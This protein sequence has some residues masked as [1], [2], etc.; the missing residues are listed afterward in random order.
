MA[1]LSSQ[2]GFVENQIYS[3]LILENLHEG[4]LPDIYFRNVTDFASGGTL[5][6]PTVGAVTLQDI[7]EDEDPTYNPIDSGTVN[8]TITEQVGDAWYITDDMRED[9][10]LVDSL[11]AARADEGSRALKEYFQ[12]TAFQALY[13]AQTASD[14]NN[15]NGFSHRF[16]AS[17]G[18]EQMLIGDFNDMGLAFDKAN[19]P[20]QGRV[21]IVD[22]V[23]A[24]TLEKAYNVNYNV[25]SNP[26]LQAILEA[27]LGEGMQF[28][29]NLAGWNVFTSNLLPDVAAGTNIDGSDSV[30]GAGKANLFLNIGDD[31]VTPLMAAWRRMPKTEFER[32]KDKRR[33]EFVMSARWGFGAQRT[34]TLGVVVTDATAT[35]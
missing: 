6:I 31:N 21:A 12:T 28:R 34:D 32:N 5:N 1:I 35:A 4:L 18:N 8:L 15:V 33:D 13:D 2:T 14:P 22:P 26:T 10:Y 16:L 7:T 20:A 23:V 24:T 3:Q 29:M 19:A 9:G 27:G 11:L 25:D 17:G 30:T